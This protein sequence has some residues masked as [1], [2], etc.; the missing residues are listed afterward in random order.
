MGSHNLKQHTEPKVLEE[1]EGYRL[2]D[3]PLHLESFLQ[4]IQMI[5]IRANGFLPES[6]FHSM[7][8]KF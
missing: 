8:K 6:E 7:Y 3:F 1:N 5:K 4:V 2:I